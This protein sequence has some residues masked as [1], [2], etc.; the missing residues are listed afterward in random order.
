MRRTFLL[1]SLLLLCALVAGSSSVWADEVT[2]AYSGTST[3]NMTGNNDAATL[4]LDEDEWSV[5]AVPT[6]AATPL[7][8]GLNKAGN[9]RLYYNETTSNSI[10]V[11]SNNNSTI[12]SITVTYGTETKSKVLY[13]RNGAA[14]MVGTET[15]TDTNDD[16][17]IGQY[18]INSTSFTIQNVNSSNVQVWIV[19]IV[20]N[21]TPSGGSKPAP[22]FSLDI[23][24]KTLA[25]YGNETVD[26]TLTTNTDGTITCE[27]SNDV[28]ATVALKSD[29]VYT[30]TA[31]SEGSATIT[32]KS[33]SSDNYAAASATVAI[34]VTD[35]RADAGISFANNSEETTW[36]EEFLGQNLTNT[37]SLPVSWSS[38]DETVATVNQSGVVNVLKA[39]TTTIKATFAGNAAYKN[40]VASYTL[41]VNKASAGLSYTTTSFDIILNDDSF[42]APTLNNP[43]G[44]TGITYASNNTDV[45]FVD[46]T[47]GELLYESSA[48]GT[49]K[50]TA[51]F[52]GNDNYYPGSANYTINIVDPNEKGTKYNPYTVS[53]VLAA[54]SNISSVYVEGYIVGFV[55]GTT[56]FT[57][58]PGSNQNSNWALADD[59]SET[60]FANVTPVEIKS[61]N[62]TNLGI[63]N[64]PELLGAK[65]IMKGNI[66]NYFGKKGVKSPSEITIESVSIPVGQYLWGTF[67][68]NQI[69][70]F[71]GSDV[72]AY[73]VTG[74]EDNVLT[75]SEVTTVAANTPLLVNASAQGAYDIPVAASGTDYSSTNKMKA[76]TGAAVSAESGKTKY[77]LS[78]DDDDKVAFMKIGSTAATVAKG[79][80]YLQFDEEIAAPALGFGDATG[81]TSLTPTLSE[82]E[83]DVYNLNGQRVAQP[84]KGLYIVNGRKVVVK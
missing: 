72:A 58:K 54:N 41:T 79:K 80:A 75:K 61:A 71:T 43:N 7:Y 70:D 13:H 51:S 83:G 49:A 10:T 50:I 35:N 24:E 3:T 14:V 40:D 31:Q 6:G 76:G 22:T 84:T 17:D 4:G 60:V 2:L 25:A 38:T 82:G 8:P 45:A 9:I 62:Q 18:A 65:V 1:K 42:V 68:C 23:T 44:L 15:I 64:H 57:A 63:G 27:S 20:I 69:L 81:I 34:T 33:A 11:S 28:V 59:K 5:T 19:S 21:Y 16:D 12:N 77:V 55:T 46:A 32:I 74:H 52:A 37:H 66:E 78:L 67:A 36:G 26:V 39:G 48:V 73:V 56:S 53:E 47:T 29:K 30:I